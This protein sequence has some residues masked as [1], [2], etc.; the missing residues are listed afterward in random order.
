MV[1]L[2]AAITPARAQSAAPLQFV[3]RAQLSDAETAQ[4]GRFISLAGDD[5][6]IAGL[7]WA[8]SIFPR[9]FVFHRSGGTWSEQA[10]FGIDG[11]T[12]VASCSTVSTPLAIEGD[13]LAIG[14]PGNPFPN[15]RAWTSRRT[16]STWSAPVYA[17]DPSDFFYYFGQS[18]LLRE[19]ALFAGA[20]NDGFPGDVQ[21]FLDSPSGWQQQAEIGPGG[22]AFGDAIV[23]SGNTIAVAE[24]PDVR[25]Y[26]QGASVLDW[27]FQ[28]QLDPP[29][30]A[31]VRAV[32]LDG[33]TAVVSTT[34]NE[35]SC[36]THTQPAG[37]YV[38]ER[39]GTAWTQTATL[40]S[41]EASGDE[42]GLSL[43]ISGDTIYVGTSAAASSNVGAVIVFRRLGPGWVQASRLAP[44]PALPAESYFGSA[45][46]LDGSTLC[47][48]APGRMANAGEVQ[49]FDVVELPAP[50]SY[51]TAK[52]NSQGC[53]PAMSASGIPSATSTDPFDLRATNVLNNKTGILLYTRAGAA[54]HPYMGGTLCVAQPFK[55]LNAG[56][57]HGNPPPNDCSGSYAVD[58]NARIRSGVDPG[59][60]PG[61]QVWVQYVT[62]DPGDPTTLGLTDA[63]AFT[64]GS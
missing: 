31:K 61:V 6:L 39:S 53:L 25:V 14:S 50:Q 37:V 62:R 43:A 8:P 18:V 46:A 55:R 58:F 13:L 15:G 5:V 4:F 38:F 59:L 26:T 19:G 57:S 52:V 9:Q 22:V 23:A 11:L 36:G 45:L 33:D 40:S 60:Q 24:S 20:P 47:A 51:C 29:G 44:S 21:V 35:A 34:T 17:V 3:P 10:S 48:G 32:A 63:I 27:S 12:F 41:S 56:S 54:S 42:F 64:I 49:V 30:D 7:G 28:A 2:A 16:G 1:I